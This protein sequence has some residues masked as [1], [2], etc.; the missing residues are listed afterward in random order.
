MTVSVSLLGRKKSKLKSLRTRLFGRNKKTGEEGNSK[1]SQ[2][3][4]DITAG[5]TLGSDEDLVCSQGMMGSRALSHDSI[6]LA[7]Q[8]L[9]DA[10][11]VRVLSQ[12]NVHSKIKA[13]QLQ[14]QK[15][16]LGLPPP[17][18]SMRRPED[19]GS[20][21]EDDSLPHSPSEI[22]AG[23]VLG[24]HPLPPIPKPAPTKSVSPTFPVLS[25]S[26]PPVVEPPLDFSSPAQFTPCLDTS[27]ARHRMS[28]K[29]RNQRASTKKR[30]PGSDSGS[31]LHNLNN[32]ECL[33]EEE[34]QLET[35]AEETV[36]TDR[37]GSDIP[38][39]SRGPFK[40]P[41]PAPAPS[42]T[43][44]KTSS[45]GFSQQDSAPPVKAL[46]SSSQVL[47]NKPHRSVDIIRPHSSY[48]QSDLMEK[49]EST[50]DFNI[51]IMPPDKRD[52]QNKGGAT[53]FKSKKDQ[54]SS[55]SGSAVTFRSS[56]VQGETENTRGIK[57]PAPGSGSFHFSVTTAKN[58]DAERPRSG[59]FVGVL[60]NTGAQLKTGEGK[61]DTS[62]SIMREKEDVKD[63]RPRGGPADVGR[64]RQE[65]ALHKSPVLPWDRDSLKKV[66]SVTQSKNI[67]TDA[68]AIDREE[69][70]GSQEAMEEAVE[71]KEVHEEEGKTAF[72]VKLR[73]TSQSVRLRSEVSSYQQSK[74]TLRE[75]QS[76]KQR[77]EISNNASFIVKKQPV[78]VSCAA[79][80]SGDARPTGES[81]HN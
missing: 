27:A 49:P 29:P 57:R 53:D 9:T 6:F 70:E 24:S 25:N 54:F 45:L 67:T 18:L 34:P 21:S 1:L 30:L 41:E 8:A 12:E 80:T 63:L 32:T 75:E 77:Q 22:S 40:I 55:S 72:G 42:E 73:S 46:P 64:L 15:L 23:H 61:E 60:E 3:A 69:P 35:Q 20:R 56:G 7:D 66:E 59:S 43:A 2:S 81:D 31:L 14:Q 11:P 74:S 47:R 48:V 4:S 26:S 10:E 52:T 36:E 71:A 78:N 44:P 39:T 65:G 62:P 38:F 76:E 50:G 19:P 16:H 28:V 17:V 58:R 5:K 33:T 51:Q 13:L 37:G 68:G 79:S